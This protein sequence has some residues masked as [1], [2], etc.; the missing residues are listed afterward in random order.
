MTAEVQTG[1]TFTV[2]GAPVTAYVGTDDAAGSMAGNAWNGKWITFVVE[3]GTLNFK[4]GGGKVTVT[5]LT[6]D[7]LMT[8]V[9]SK[10]FQGSK[11]LMSVDGKFGILAFAYYNTGCYRTYWDG[12]KYQVLESSSAIW[13][14]V[15]VVGKVK[16]LIIAYG[17][18]MGGLVLVNA[19][20]INIA[21]LPRGIHEFGEDDITSNTIS[22][23]GQGQ[24]CAF[25]ALGTLE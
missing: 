24:K 14:P 21:E 7:A 15:T 16:K 18:G 11:E 22:S 17:G 8:G 10:I 4:G 5:G 23:N 1:D 6:A 25:I 19:F 12:E 3:G 13:Q 20:G 2:N 9:T